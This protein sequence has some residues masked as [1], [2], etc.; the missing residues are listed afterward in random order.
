MSQ[1]RLIRTVTV[2][3]VAILS[4]LLAGA[5]PSAASADTT[6]PGTPMFGYA[7]GFQCLTLII[8][9]PRVTDNVTP[10]S[11]ITYRVLA[12]GVDIGALSDRG[13][14]SG[15]WAVLQLPQAGPNSVVVQAV[16]LAG[17]R[18]TSR[19]VPVTGYFT[20]GCTPWHF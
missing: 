18:S 20:P 12:N 16:D 7:Q 19:T 17:N 1:P 3:A 5:A 11:Q 2:A 13:A 14:D 6:P 10:Q 4:A 8:G 15:V 9:V